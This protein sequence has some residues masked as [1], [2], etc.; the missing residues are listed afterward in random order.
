MFDRVVCIPACQEYQYL[1]KTIQ[2]L[3][4]LPEKCLLILL[5][6]C[7]VDSPVHIVKDNLLLHNWLLQHPYRQQQNEYWIEFPD[8]PILY[9]DHS[10]EEYRFS[11]KQGVGYARKLL[12]ERA[13]SLMD[14]GLISSPW[15]WCSDGDARFQSSYLTEPPTCA[16]AITPYIHKP[17]TPEL[18]IYEASLRYYSLGLDWAQSP[19]P[20]PTI[21]STI[22]IHKDSY[23]KIHGFSDRQAAE[24]FYLLNK[25]AK[26]GSIYYRDVPP[27]YLEGRCSDRVPFGTGRAMKEIKDN[28]L[29]L[30]VYD[31]RIFS[32]LKRWFKVLYTSPDQSLL[33]DLDQI[34]P[35]YPARHKLAKVLKQGCN[36]KTQIRRR[37]EFFD[38]FQTMRFIHHL[39]DTQYPSIPYQQALQQASF[40]PEMPSDLL[41]IQ[42]HLYQLERERLV[43]RH[44]KL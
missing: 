28:Q 7:R 26:V 17:A 1:P 19:H 20:F 30:E 4:K 5:N 14:S 39:R 24:D 41:L 3:A 38:L 44:Y 35:S 40:I 21:G 34:L 31:P 16:A 29:Q 11:S 42:N 2:S 32:I 22:V 8:L 6:N 27:I 9:L 25:A 36:P 23:Q 15:I 37:L 33:S 12:A 18:L 10:S 43:G 13:L